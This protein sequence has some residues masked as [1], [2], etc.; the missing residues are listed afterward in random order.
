VAVGGAEEWGVFGR[1]AVFLKSGEFMPVVKW[2]NLFIITSI[3]LL[4]W[5]LYKYHIIGRSVAFITSDPKKYGTLAQWVSA[6]ATFSAVLVALFWQDIL[7]YFKRPKLQVEI[8]LS[9]PDCHKTKLSYQRAPGQAIQHADCYYFRIWVENIGK[10]RAEKV[11]VFASKLYRKN[12][13][14]K[15]RETTS[16]S[17]MNLCWAH[18]QPGKGPEVF[19]DGISPEM[20]KHCDLAHII[21]PLHQNAI[22]P[23]IEVGFGEAVLTLDLEVKPNTLG[24]QIK[25]GDYWLVLLVAAANCKPVTKMLDISFSGTWYDNETKMFSEGIVIRPIG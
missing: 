20:G 22:E 17:P 24:H 3:C 23:S 8:K 11:Q 5:G 2:K 4:L 25:P 18:A 7:R 19:A 13:E 10:S 15:Y 21:H 16:F 1:S 14:D 6:C 12:D 9:Q